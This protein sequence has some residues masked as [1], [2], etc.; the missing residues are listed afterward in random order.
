MSDKSPEASL[1]GSMVFEEM[2]R[3]EKL[4]SFGKKASS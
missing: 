4:E 3:L 1:N 2:P